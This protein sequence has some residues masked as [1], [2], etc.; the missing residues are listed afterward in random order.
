MKSFLWRN[1][2]FVH[3]ILSNINIYRMVRKRLIE[4]TV[5][6]PGEGWSFWGQQTF[7]F[8]YTKMKYLVVALPNLCL[9]MDDGELMG[10]FNRDHVRILIWCITRLILDQSPVNVADIGPALAQHWPSI[11]LTYLWFDSS[12]SAVCAKTSAVGRLTRR[13]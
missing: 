11:G 1:I 9:G 13:S 6:Y 3:C 2:P 7:L 12:A 8:Y 10:S 4:T 5:D